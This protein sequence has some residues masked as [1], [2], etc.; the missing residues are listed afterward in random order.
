MSAMKTT[1]TM[2]RPSRSILVAAPALLVLLLA[3]HAAGAAPGQTHTSSH[4]QTHHN[5]L[6][7]DLDRDDEHLDWESDGRVLA[8]RNAADGIAVT[9]VHPDAQFGLHAG[10]VID[11]VDGQSTRTLSD[12]LA[13]LKR[14]QGHGVSLGMHDDAGHQHQ[15]R[16]AAADYADWLPPSPPAPP[17]APQPPPAPPTPGH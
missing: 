4:S 12:L 1:Q 5:A 14:N 7:V 13:A 11:A 17:S 6:H 2:H 9:R 10:E 16:L 15:V 8:L 3:G